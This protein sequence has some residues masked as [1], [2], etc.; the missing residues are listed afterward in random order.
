VPLSD[1]ADIQISTTGGG[2]SLPGFGTCLVLGGYSKTWVERVRTYASLAEIAVDFGTT[3]PE[4]KAAEKLFSQNPR[5]T[6]VKVGRG[7]LPPTQRWKIAVASVKNST[8]YKV[9]VRDNEASFTSD[10]DALNDEIVA[11][12]VTAVNALAGDGVTAS[13]VGSVGSQYVQL[14]GTAGSWDWVEVLDTNL[15]SLEQDHA[16]PGVATDLAAIHLY[17]PDWYALVTCWNS[18]ACVLAAAAWVE[19]N[20]KLYVVQT[21]DTPVIATA[22]GVATDV[23]KTVKDL[24]YARTS[25]WYDP[26][27]ATFLDAALLGRCLP[28]E[29]GSETWAMK[30][31]AGVPAR[32]YT[33]THLTNLKAKRCGWYYAIAGRNVTFEGK[34]AANEWIDTIRGRDALK[35]DMQGRIFQRLADAEK[36]PYTDA[37]ATVVQ[38]EIQASLDAFV[39]R[40]FIAEGSVEVFVPAV[41]DQNPTDRSNRYFPGITFGGDLA[42]AIHK[43]AIV[44]RLSP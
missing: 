11:G 23:A 16:D 24:A 13:A 2:L 3:T 7:T 26:A 32:S 18:K 5:P 40:G 38:G 29:P 9:K 27:T 41:S 21:Q 20:E 22:E 35:V 14:L 43:L 1:V 39:R 37:G 6:R 25:V 12:L 31:L 17:D 28:L 10:A 36:I 15:L 33:G 19:A 30:T 8:A 34:V 44:G 42:G 4:Y